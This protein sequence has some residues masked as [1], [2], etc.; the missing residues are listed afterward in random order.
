MLCRRGNLEL[1]EEGARSA[2]ELRHAYRLVPSV[3]RVPDGVGTA[4]RDAR[5]QGLGG[6]RALYPRVRAEAVSGY[7]AHEPKRCRVDRTAVR[8]VDDEGEDSVW[9]E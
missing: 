5:E 7:S 3:E 8:T 9:R 6:E 2:A 1:V 4:L